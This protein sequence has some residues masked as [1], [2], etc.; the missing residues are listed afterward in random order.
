ML[1]ST[2]IPRA[3]AA[4]LL[5]AFVSCAMAQAQPP[6]P[7]AQELPLF[8]VEITTGPKWDQSKPP[9]DQAHFKEHSSNLKR[10]RDAGSLVMG[11]RYSDKGLVV[12]AAHS[13][14]HARAMMDEDPSMKAE[15]FKYT[16]FPFSVFYPGSVYAKPRRIEK[17]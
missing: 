2:T 13:E 17:P 3:L 11:A 12:L 5:A 1:R 14:A 4:L 6:A 10:L 16:L 8:A 7:A 15:V 9:Q